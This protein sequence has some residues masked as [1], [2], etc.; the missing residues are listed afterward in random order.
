MFDEPGGDQLRTEKGAPAVAEAGTA[1][2]QVWLAPRECQPCLFPKPARA[3]KAQY[4][5]SRHTELVPA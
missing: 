3:S 2:S 1:C 5:V 4:A